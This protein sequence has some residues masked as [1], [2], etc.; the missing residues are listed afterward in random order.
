MPTVD[1]AALTDLH[2]FSA[3]LSAL[4]RD[5]PTLSTPP[6]ERAD[7]FDRKAE[8][9]ERVAV[10][11]PEAAELAAAARTRAAELRRGGAA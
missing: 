7:W 5:W 3:D 11:A 2:T 6:A 9:L 10:I 8:L 4:L 1:Q